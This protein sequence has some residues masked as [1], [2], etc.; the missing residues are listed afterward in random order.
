MRYITAVSLAQAKRQAAADHILAAARTLVLQG[1][2]DV[3]M[4][5]LAE[6][7]GVSRRTLFRH[8]D[9]REKLLGAAFEVGMAGYRRDLP[10]YTEYPGD[11]DRW[12]RATCE[13]AHRMNAA[14]GPGFFELA[15]RKDLPPDL[16]AAEKRRRRE[17]RGAMADIVAVLWRERGHRGSPS[18]ALLT[19]VTT[20]LSPHFTAASTIDAG[21]SWRTAADLAYT[22]ISNH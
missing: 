4:D 22:A 18:E 13:A 15:S 6:V 1:G 9:T 20:H 21:Q 17:F 10:S 14:I 3:T 8:F 11:V 16:A 7:T 2:L 5:Q 12:L 19:T